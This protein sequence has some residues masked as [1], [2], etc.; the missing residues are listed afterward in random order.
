MIRRLVSAVCTALV[1][2]FMIDALANS[3]TSGAISASDIKTITGQLTF[4]SKKR[5]QRVVVVCSVVVT[6][7]GDIDSSRCDSARGK[8]HYATQI[9]RVLTSHRVRPAMVDGKP[10]SVAL[11]LM[12][13][14][15]PTGSGSNI[16][17]FLHNAA[18]AERNGMDYVGP[19]LVL[20]SRDT[21]P[22]RTC[23]SAVDFWTTSEVGVTGR[24]ERLTHSK[25][26]AVRVC[27]DAVLDA[28]KTS[29]FIPAHKDNQPIA[30]RYV[31]RWIR[32]TTDDGFAAD[33]IRWGLHGGHSPIVKPRSS[34][35]DQQ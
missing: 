33:G 12:V 31:E 35:K 23:S 26:R 22:H 2:C 19:Q 15:S 20:Q 17:L 34:N 8:L 18:D 28:I 13:V 29:Q 6:D 14:H 1:T 7:E 25:G 10:V 4:S 30:G 16:Y 11:N 3:P 24:V 27:R 32:D 21:R 5:L 9:Q